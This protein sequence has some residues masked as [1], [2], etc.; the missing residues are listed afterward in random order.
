MKVIVRLVE[1]VRNA[2]LYNPEVQSAPACVLWPD[3]ERQWEA[4]IPRLRSELPELFILGV[5]DPEKRT[6]P[7]IWLRCV[8]AGKIE[9]IEIPQD[10]VPI[11]YLPGIGRQDLRAVEKCPD[12][13]KP[14]A[15]LQYRGVL[16]TQKNAKDWTILAFL[17]SEKGGLGLDVALDTD[18][19]NSMQRA[20]TLLL[21]EDVD[22]LRGKRL[23]KDYF[24]TLL[25][26]G[27]PVRDLL[28]WLDQG[29]LIQESWG[30][31]KWLAFVAVCKSQF[32]FDPESK[33]ILEGAVKLAEHKGPW[34]PVWTRFCE[35]P[36]RYP[37]IPTQIRRASTSMPPADLLS[38]AETHGGWPQWNERE[39]STLRDD[40]LQLMDKPPHKVRDEIKQYEEKHKDRRNL[41]WAELGEAPLALA[42][43]HLAV[44]AEVTSHSIAGGTLEDLV[45]A[46]MTSG[47]QADDAVLRA[48]ECAIGNQGLEAVSVAIRSM[49]LPW[50]EDA[51][52]R[53][54]EL[55]EQEG[56][57]GQRT[58]TGKAGFADKGECVLFIDGLR[59]DVAKRLSDSLEG[60]GF[61]LEE[62][63]T[64]AALP[65]VTSTGKPAVSPVAH[66]LAGK[67]ATRDFEPCVAAT[68]QSLRGGQYLRR[69]L[70]ESGWQILEKDET[71]DPDGNAWVEFGNLDNE[72]HHRGLSVAKYVSSQLK[73]IADRIGQLLKAGWMRVR[74]VTDHGWLLLPGGLPKCD[75][76][77]VLTEY[78]WG[79]CALIK[80]GAR[81]DERTFPWHWD[82]DQK[83][84]LAS[85]ISC[86]RKGNEYAHG[87]LS[88]QE[89]LLLELT[90]TT[91]K[92]G[93]LKRTVEFTAVEWRGLRCRVSVRGDCSGLSIDIRTQ[94]GNRDTS[95]V[96][97][98]SEITGEGSGSVVVEDEDMQGLSAVIL[99]IDEEDQTIA[100]R[101]TVIGGGEV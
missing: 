43:K 83:V 100:Q 50:A 27:D 4:A 8:I 89:C 72:G 98:M 31:E 57:P 41:V 18:T 21:D 74:V 95:V 19:K 88:L 44:L 25:T 66:L 54:Q 49:Y 85:G 1:L 56:Y 84:A 68:G 63:I 14:L 97:A 99:L 32:A 48:L 92:A 28:Q 46:Y 6:G 29:D 13:L 39:E 47:W 16:W 42:L 9:G 61:D 65:S 77:A 38:N 86:Y 24:N 53:L 71:G 55:S 11:L 93:I 23:D 80:A 26:G 15:E 34:Q 35:A 81:C 3:K 78:K 17:K 40:L 62:H 64:W 52:R 79:R 5:Y 12:E 73:E 70:K 96:A 7:A 58:A 2:A 69:L 22:L 37:G 59:F 45:G 51:A 36:M 82:V 91:G 20:L 90:V 10:R 87:G 60:M 30:E 76:P 94:A 33:G 75:L 101:D 67:E